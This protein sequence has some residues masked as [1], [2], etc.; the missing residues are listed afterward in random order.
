MQVPFLDLKRQYQSI[1]VEIDQAVFKV[2]AETQF[3]LGPEVKEFE[4]NIA[5]Y[6][7]AKFAIGVASGTD[8][9]L[10]ALRACGVKEGDE[11]ITSPFTFFATAGSISR[12]KAIPVFVDIQPDTYNIDP[13]LIEKKITKKTRVIIPV[14]LYGQCA[15]MELILEI[16][17]VHNLKVIE[18]AAQAISST[19]KSKKAGTLGDMGIFSFFPSKNL[20]GIGDGGMVITDNE[21]LAQ[22]VSLLR[23]H[24]AKPKYY[25]SLIG[26]NSRLD[27]IQAAV[28]NVKLK[29]L[30]IWSKKRRENA[31]FYDTAFKGTK[32]ETPYQAPYSYHI[33]HQYTIAVKNLAKLKEYLKEKKIGHDSYYPLPLHLQ[34]CY[35]DLGYK[36]GDL[37]NSEQ[38]AQEVI[39]LPIYP[40][41]TSEE[42]EYVAETIKSYA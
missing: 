42:M 7:G 19:Y 36:S 2:L 18:D 21:E 29:Y 25:H 31:S 9:L 4:K 16:A 24:G 23:V 38:R 20:G 28:L 15:D 26:Y 14:H 32:I 40:E 33:F 11:I 10:L 30:D 27:T 6:C 41:L 13:N 22:K 37:P 3:I 8:A 17:R 1:K 35:K 34:E 12:L 39:S 5:D